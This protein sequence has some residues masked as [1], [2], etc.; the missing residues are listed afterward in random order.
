[1]H[2]SQKVEATK[3]L[4]NGWMNEQN[5]VCACNGILNKEG[6][7]SKMMDF[8]R[9]PV[10]KSLP[11]SI[12]DRGSTPGPGTKRP[13][14]TG[15]VGPRAITTQPVLSS[16]CTATPEASAPQSP[17]SAMRSHHNEQPARCN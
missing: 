4:I 2:N 5:A 8:S 12:G 7:M 11:A 17:C 13:H 14:A 1:M 10:V 16:P 6:K 3:L 15:Q 9:G